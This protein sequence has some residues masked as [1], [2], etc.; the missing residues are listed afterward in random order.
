MVQF[1]PSPLED[2]ESYL[3]VG[4]QRINVRVQV[5][6][7]RYFVL[8]TP[9]NSRNRFS[10]DYWNKAKSWHFTFLKHLTIVPSMKTHYLQGVIHTDTLDG[11]KVLTTWTTTKT[12]ANAEAEKFRSQDAVLARVMRDGRSGFRIVGY[13]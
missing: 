8:S 10:F 2:R 7:S 9:A 12:H 13:W 3:E 11:R 1:H 4:G 6:D 5:P